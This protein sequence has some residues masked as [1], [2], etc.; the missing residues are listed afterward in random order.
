MSLETNELNIRF[1][2]F[3]IAYIQKKKERKNFR[4]SVDHHHRFVD[5]NLTE[6]DNRLIEN[7]FVSFVLTID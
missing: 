1:L 7:E 3:F 6:N 4:I 5:N 2:L